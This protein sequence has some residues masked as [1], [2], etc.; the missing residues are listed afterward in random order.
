MTGE[1]RGQVFQLADRVKVKVTTVNI[2]EQKID[3]EL[4]E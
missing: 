3:F 1:R 2:D 4:A